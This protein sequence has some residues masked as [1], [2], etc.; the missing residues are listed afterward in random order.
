MRW[1]LV[2][3]QIV[4]LIL[5][6]LGGYIAGAAA[7]GMMAARPTATTEVAP[8]LDL[9]VDVQ[10]RLIPPTNR[11]QAADRGRWTKASELPPIC[12]TEE[13]A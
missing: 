5:V 1:I 6:L 11:V 7:S 13:S 10:G 12:L 4:V 9:R 3:V 2:P 8:S